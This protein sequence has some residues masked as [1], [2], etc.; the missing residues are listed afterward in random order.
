MKR[1]SPARPSRKSLTYRDA[2]VDIDAGDALVDRIKPH[3]KRTLRPGVMAGIGG[4]GALFAM[5]RG[6]R[7]PVLVS[8]TDGVGTKLKLA[9]EW[10]RHDT[11]GIDLVA[12]SVNDI[13]TL[14][15]EPLFFLD[16]YACGK[17]DVDSAA[18]V[19]EGIAAG[20]EMAG[21]ALI[22][23]ETAEMPG[24]YPAGEYDLAGFAVGVVE[25]KRIINGRSIRPGDVILGLGSNGAHSNGYSL[26]RKII[27]QRGV[28]LSA[29]VGGRALKDLIL[30]PTR[31]YVRPLLKLMKRLPVKG[32]AHI[33][34]GGLL[35]NVPRV[36]GTKLT[37]EISRDA[38]PLPPLFR[39]LQQQGNVADDEMHRV[40]NCGIGMVVVVAEKDA[41][42][43]QALLKRAGE[44]VWRIGSVRRRRGSEA[45]TVVI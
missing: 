43:A 2:G 41:A 17:L 36:L 35:D 31:I 7:E 32:L 18:D 11:I 33:T 14:G 34:G 26:I 19:V 16:Y 28:K 37:A 8:G 27:A 6:Y 23:G 9:F 25:K 45:Q 10:R 1:K 39:W 38:W 40:F 29:K 15:A 22:G 42:R 30:A 5:P 20:C 44:R 4:F 13:L 3:A 21:C 24:M 12:M